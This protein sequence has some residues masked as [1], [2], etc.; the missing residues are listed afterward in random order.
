MGTVARV[1]RA[2]ALLRRR[3]PFMFGGASWRELH[4]A[5]DVGGGLGADPDFEVARRRGR[6][7]CPVPVAGA[8]KAIL[9]ASGFAFA[10]PANPPRPLLKSTSAFSAP[11]GTVTLSRRT[12]RDPIAE[13]LYCAGLGA[14]P[15]WVPC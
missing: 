5:Q 10:V 4:D 11:A 7:C 3:G 6:D 1:V 9:G 15:P 14:G 12:G 13:L 8:P 2:S